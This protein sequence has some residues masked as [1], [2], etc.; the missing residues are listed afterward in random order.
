MEITTYYNE[1]FNRLING[2]ILEDLEQCPIDSGLYLLYPRFEIGS[3]YNWLKVGMTV[4]STG[5]RSR[6][7]THFKSELKQV[8]FIDGRKKLIDTEL[9]L[10]SKRKSLKLNE[11]KSSFSSILGK[12]LW[13]DDEFSKRS[14]FDLTSRIER[15]IFILSHCYFKILPLPQYNWTTTEEKNSVK[16]NLRD[17]ESWIEKKYRQNIRY[18]GRVRHRL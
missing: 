4:D 7:S 16:K 12:H 13:F 15:E 1:Y 8:I 11:V 10:Y 6:I 9:L 14:G 2:E 5:L 18:I 17:I 3:N